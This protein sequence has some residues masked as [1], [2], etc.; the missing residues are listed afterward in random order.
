MPVIAVVDY[1]I[2]NLHS[3]C[4]GLKKAGA[5]TIVT[6]SPAEIDRADAV[7]LPGVGA[8]DPAMENLRDRSL[9]EPL[10]A[11]AAAGKPFFG[12]CVG[13]QVL[14]EGSEEGD[15]P[16]LGI[17]PGYVRRFQP[18]PDLTI[19][20]MGWNDLQLVQPHCTLFQDLGPQPYAYFVHSYYCE[21]KDPQAVAATVTHGRQTIAAAIARDNLV[22][23]Q[24]HPEKSS[25][26]GLKILAN[27]VARAAATKQQ[28][29]APPVAR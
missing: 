19:P 18:E 22:A 29:A 14:F 17:V 5:E 28:H 7:V 21:P 13:M 26:V 10:Q 2:G 12:I 23:V 8:F 24:F 11:A 1:D 9:V 6:A 3:A 4:K 20:H 25:T 27:F 16:G 15:E